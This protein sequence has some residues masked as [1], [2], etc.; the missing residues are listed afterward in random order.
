MEEEVVLVNKKGKGKTGLLK[1]FDG[2]IGL[3]F[4]LHQLAQHKVTAEES[5]FPGSYSCIFKNLKQ[6]DTLSF[7]V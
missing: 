5:L 4:Q 7:N 3:M 1:M 6:T 2:F